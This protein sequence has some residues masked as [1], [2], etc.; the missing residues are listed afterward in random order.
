[1]ETILKSLKR[2]DNN[3]ITVKV[4]PQTNHE[5]NT[6]DSRKRYEFS[7]DFL[8]TISDWILKLVEE[9]KVKIR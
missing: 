9:K 1:M 3:N 2:G 6:S 4:F 7:P 5:F 8:Q